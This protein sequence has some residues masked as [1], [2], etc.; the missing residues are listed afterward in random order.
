VELLDA[1]VGEGS[2]VYRFRIYRGAGIEVAELSWPYGPL[3]HETWTDNGDRWIYVTTTH[4]DVDRDAKITIR[5]SDGARYRFSLRAPTLM[6]ALKD[7][8]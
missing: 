6:K 7:L 8:L 1:T 2:V 3:N 4:A 5:L